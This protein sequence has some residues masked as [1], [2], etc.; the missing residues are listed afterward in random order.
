MTEET[1]DIKI[2]EFLISIEEANAFIEANPTATLA[3]VKKE[4]PDLTAAAIAK[5]KKK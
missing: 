3:Q 1:L 4:F 2:G 5:K